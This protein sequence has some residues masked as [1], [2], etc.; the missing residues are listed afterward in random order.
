MDHKPL[1]PAGHTSI[2]RMA[3]FG[4]L[5]HFYGLEETDNLVSVFLA[6]KTPVYVTRHWRGYGNS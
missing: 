2:T 1:S 4:L 3:V 5:R 6:E